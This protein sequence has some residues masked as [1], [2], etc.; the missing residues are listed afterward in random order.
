VFSTREAV[1]NQNFHPSMSN[2]PSASTAF[3]RFTPAHAAFLDLC[4]AS[5][6]Y[7]LQSYSFGPWRWATYGAASK[8]LS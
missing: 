2:S 3:P 6:A 4:R 5:W 8:R 7:L 1:P